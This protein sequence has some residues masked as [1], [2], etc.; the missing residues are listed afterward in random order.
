VLRDDEVDLADEIFGAVKGSP[1]DGPLGDDVEPDLDLIE[2]GSIS[3]CV[4]HMETK[5]CRQ[6]AAHLLMLVSRVVVDYEVEV[7][8]YRNVGVDLI[9]EPQELLMAMT[10]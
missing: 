6:P 10:R 3:R 4:V 9:E 5:P 7:E 8:L 2:P 1:A